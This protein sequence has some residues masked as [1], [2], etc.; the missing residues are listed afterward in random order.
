MKKITLY[1][2]CLALGVVT[3]FTACEKDTA[4]IAGF[5]TTEGNA[6]LR[7]AHAAPSFRSIFN[8]PDSFN[9]YVNGSKVNAPFITYASVFPTT[10]NTY[11]A[12]APGLQQIKISVH[13]FNSIQPDSTLITNFTKVFQAGQ[14]YTLLIT[15]SIKS[16][17][18]S[19]QMFLPDAYSK[20][21]PGNYGLRF[22]HAVL[23]DTAGKNIDVFSTR[24]NANIYNN[25]KPGTI[26]SF[27]SL[28]Y[29]TQLNDTLYVRRAGT[30]FNLSSA[31]FGAGNQRVYTIVYR[32][33]GDLTTT[34][35]A[36]LMASFV[37][38]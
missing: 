18:D 6:F 15:D 30:L 27:S 25:I 24:R 7:V 23:N 28:A 35:K 37:H 4:K 1:I 21:S 22:V 13:G 17:K 9:V 10:S 33:N 11:F 31:V 19:A 2:S 14:Y 26:T 16:V 38:Q 3:L 20:P 8:A 32:G 12:V 29:N 5:T 36:R 34:T